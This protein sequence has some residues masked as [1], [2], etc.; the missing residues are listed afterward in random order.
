MAR[1][2]WC[3]AGWRLL[4]DGC[5]NRVQRVGDDLFVTN[6]KIIDAAI[7]QRVA[8]AVLICERGVA[9]V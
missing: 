3:R 5:D 8:N 6:P 2:R 9:W 1:T 7:R 4:T